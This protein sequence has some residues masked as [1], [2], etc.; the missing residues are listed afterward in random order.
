ME[1]RIKRETE[2]YG[3]YTPAEARAY[4]G[5]GR[6]APDDLASTDGASWRPL[7][8]VLAGLAGGS[9]ATGGYPPGGL[10]PRF[11]AT[12]LDLLIGLVFLLPGLLALL[13]KFDVGMSEGD[14]MLLVGGAIAA[15]AYGFVKD[16]LGRGQS[17]GKRATGLMVVHLPTNRPCSIGRSAVRTLVLYLSNVLPFVGW[18]IEPILVIVTQDRRRLGDRAASTQVIRVADY[19]P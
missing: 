12:M 6:L 5:E 8:E 14:E 2:Q 18:L 10:A 17:L 3:P 9:P 4:L 13:S 7:E 1:I 15:F 19:R 11:G 16:G